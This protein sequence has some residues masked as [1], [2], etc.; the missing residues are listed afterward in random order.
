[1]DERSTNINYL[2]FIEDI[3]ILYYIYRIINKVQINKYFTYNY[4][5]LIYK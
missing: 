1:M 3:S 5:K 4:I 2:C